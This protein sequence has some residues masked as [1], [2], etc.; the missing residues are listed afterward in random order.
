MAQPHDPRAQLAAYLKDHNIEE[1]IQVGGWL[2]WVAIG[3]ANH[4]P[5]CADDSTAP[6]KPPVLALILQGLLAELLFHK[7]AE[8]RKFIIEQLERIKAA[9]ARPIFD[10]HDLASMFDMFDVT[11]TGTI[12]AAQATA[13][14]ATALGGARA[15]EGI[16]ATA[17]ASR[18][19]KTAA[20]APP[21]PLAAKDPGARKLDKWEF[22]RAVGDVL[23]NAT[24]HC[25]LARLHGEEGEAEGETAG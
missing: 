13:A 5:L 8:P 10:A 1:I 16:A 23:I 12:T 15:A 24:P 19:G 7:P 2:S 18:G 21:N 9:G 17:A 11:K 14:L 20:A 25:Q 3:C 22:V 6:K 4:N